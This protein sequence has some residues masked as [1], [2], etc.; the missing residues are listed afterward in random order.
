MADYRR[1]LSQAVGPLA[2]LARHEHRDT[3]AQ[4][5]DVL[6]ADI[7]RYFDVVERVG[8]QQ[9]RVF[10]IG[11]REFDLQDGQRLAP[12]PLVLYGIGDQHSRDD[13][14]VEAGRD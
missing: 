8:P 10:R 13:R 6:P 5:F 9:P 11:H 14:V 2:E 7:A 3:L 1:L 4:F 12:R